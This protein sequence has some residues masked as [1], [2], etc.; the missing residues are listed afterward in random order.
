MARVHSA[1]TTALDAQRA[2][3]PYWPLSVSRSSD[4][5]WWD[6][7]TFIAFTSS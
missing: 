2:L 1:L 5:A 7:T 6:A 4:Q 3:H